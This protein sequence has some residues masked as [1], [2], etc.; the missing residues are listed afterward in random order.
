[1]PGD[2]RKCRRGDAEV[3]SK[4]FSL[5]IG[6]VSDDIGASNDTVRVSRKFVEYF[7]QSHRLPS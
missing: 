7:S 6:V 5:F 4:I 2:R 3:I 1:M